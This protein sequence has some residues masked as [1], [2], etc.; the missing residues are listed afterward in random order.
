MGNVSIYLKIPTNNM[1]ALYTIC[2]KKYAYDAVKESKKCKKRVWYT[3]QQPNR[4]ENKKHT[5][6][7]KQHSVP[8]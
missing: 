3:E 6:A 4:L 8:N 1:T 5:K 7:N 2:V